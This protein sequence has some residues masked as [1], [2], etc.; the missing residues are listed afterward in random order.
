MS[1]NLPLQLRGTLH[2][3][4][5]LTVSK[6]GLNIRRILLNVT[7]FDAKKQEVDELF[8]IAFFG[9]LAKNFNQKVG[10]EITV[11]IKLCA[12]EGVSNNGK[13]FRNVSIAGKKVSIS[14]YSN[15]TKAGASYQQQ[16]QQQQPQDDYDSIPF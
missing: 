4:E 9:D 3:V 16:Q 13:P 1:Q 6:S 2:S 7:K 8:P 10:D 5:A 12:N 15:Q 11:D 14:P